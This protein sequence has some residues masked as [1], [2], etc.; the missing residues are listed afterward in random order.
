MPVRPRPSRAATAAGL[1][2]AVLAGPAIASTVAPAVASPLSSW[3]QL[4]LAAEV[5]SVSVGDVTGDGRPDLV[6]TTGY[7]SSGVDAYRL[8]VFAQQSDGTLASPISAT[9][10][11]TY[12]S[13]MGLTLGDVNEDGRLDALVATDEGVDIF[14]QRESAL[15]YDWTAPVPE[16]RSVDLADLTG[17]GLGDLIVHTR[18]G[19]STMRQVAGD[20]TRAGIA[21]VSLGSSPTEVEAGDVTG[22]GLV[23]IVVARATR[24]E[25]FSQQFDHSFAPA[26]STEGGGE[27]PWNHINGLALA[28]ANDDGRLDVATSLG[29]NR[30]NSWLGILAQRGDGTLSPSVTR[31]SYDIPQT[32]ASAD[33]DGDGAGDLLTLHGGW[34]SLG[35]YHSNGDGGLYSEELTSIPY[36]SHYPLDG[37][38]VGDLTGDGRADVVVADD[39]GV[40][41]LRGVAPGTDTAPPDTVITSGPTATWRSRSAVVEFTATES[42]TFSCRLDAGVWAPCSSPWALTGL[43]QGSHTVQVRATD[44]AGNVDPTPAQR[45]FVVDGPETTITSGPVGTVRATS[46]QFAFTSPGAASFECALDSGAWTACTSPRAVTG[47]APGTSHVFRVRAVSGDGLV[48]S[49]PA[50]QSWSVEQAAD[51]A[52]GLSTSAA[53]A[54]KGARVT[55]TLTLRNNGPSS[56]SGLVAT[57]GVPPG[58]S[59]GTLPSGCTSSGSSVQCTSTSLTASSTVTWTVPTTVTASKGTL[60]MTSSVATASW[61]PQFGNNSASA[62]IKVGSGR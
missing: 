56:A 48:D 24:V 50:S 32:L 20:F 26:T 31:P 54:K 18:S 15:S 22:D 6:A 2:L 43:A 16:A 30:P 52:A 19:V 53:S 23:D 28:D 27:Y 39:Q 4:D 14:A 7:S 51:V 46:A 41:V 11:G 49:S 40:V 1:G 21:Q 5:Q 45:S 25:V 36:R 35:V 44:R 57:L 33:L 17:D 62:T 58:L 29:G 13:H 61:D 10:S 47:L 9:T 60:T 55:W 37:L 59:L 34:S 8:L 12:G 42:A 38:A 3:S